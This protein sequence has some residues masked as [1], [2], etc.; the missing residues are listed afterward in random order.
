MIQTS[1][2]KQPPGAAQSGPKTHRIFGAFSVLAERISDKF[3]KKD[4]WDLHLESKS[5]M[6]KAAQR[7]EYMR[8]AKEFY[9]LSRE[10]PDTSSNEGAS[11]CLGSGAGPLRK[12]ICVFGESL[13]TLNSKANEANGWSADANNLF[14]RK[15]DLL[16]KMAPYVGAYVEG[17]ADISALR[18]IGNMLLSHAED[19]SSPE[20]MADIENRYARVA[21]MFANAA[22]VALERAGA[23]QEAEKAYVLVHLIRQD[24]IRRKLAE[25][26]GLKVKKLWV[27]S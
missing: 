21:F 7:I 25:D 22:G 17:E 20:V 5:G 9:S 27:Y 19:L 8:Y 16:H 12:K 10:V 3:A 26:P 11:K 13:A 24:E 6:S 18:R 1:Q 2:L 15:L 4:E 23:S 14:R